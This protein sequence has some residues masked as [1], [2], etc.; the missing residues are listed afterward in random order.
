MTTV[1]CLR[2]SVEKKITRF[3]R[4]LDRK[5]H[6]KDALIIPNASSSLS[7]CVHFTC[8]GGYQTRCET[9]KNLQNYTIIIIIPKQISFPKWDK[10]GFNRQG[11][12]PLINFVA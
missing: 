3:Q 11:E 8:P 4:Y 9:L 10:E 1:V 6:T 12:K 7:V 5:R 2:A